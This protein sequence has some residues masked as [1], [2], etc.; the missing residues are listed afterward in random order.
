MAYQHQ[1]PAQQPY[2]PE[3]QSQPPYAPGMQPQPPYA[4]GMQPHSPYAP[5]MQ[6]QP[7]YGPGM[8]VQQQPTQ[9]VTVMTSQGPGRWSTDMCDCCSDMGTCK[10]PNG[11]DAAQQVLIILKTPQFTVITR[12]GSITDMLLGNNAKLLF[13]DPQTHSHLTGG[14]TPAAVLPMLYFDTLGVYALIS[15]KQQ[16]TFQL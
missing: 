10:F 13:S 6:P 7:P 11:I 14:D 1:Y 4:P 9:V 8:P 3:M 12:Y 5:G 2:A 16:T 15:Y